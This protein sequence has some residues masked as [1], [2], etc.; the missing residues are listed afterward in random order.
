MEITG[1]KPGPRFGW[2]LHALLEE[3]LDDPI[4]NTKEYLESKV[5]ELSTLSDEK[6]KAIGEEGKGEK[7]RSRGKRNPRAQ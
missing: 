6:L 5:K 1:E 2:M 7:R 4:K 3:I